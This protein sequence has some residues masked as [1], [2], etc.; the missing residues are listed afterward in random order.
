MEHAVM[1]V[2][3]YS[4]ARGQSTA[5][6]ITATTASLTLRPNVS[7]S[8]GVTGGHPTTEEEAVHASNRL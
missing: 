1:L 7:V 4:E 2:G 5:K 8:S 3:Q 6:T